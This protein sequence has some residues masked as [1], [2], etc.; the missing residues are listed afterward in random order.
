MK[1]FC[2]FVAVFVLAVLLLTGCAAAAL[3]LNLALNRSR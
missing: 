1:R 2:G 3:P